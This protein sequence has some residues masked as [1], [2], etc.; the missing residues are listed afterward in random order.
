M[1]HLEAASV[2][3]FERLSRE[4]RAH[5][6]PSSLVR[7]ARESA[8]D[9]VRHA[10]LAGKLAARFGGSPR[11][12][13]VRGNG[14]RSL[15]RVAKENAVEGCVR[16]TY[17]ALVAAWQ[18]THA[19]DARVRRWMRTIARDELRHAA[20]AWAIAAWANE[21]LD[22]GSRTRVA[23]ARAQALEQLRGQV[24][25]EASSAVCDVAGLPSAREARALFGAW[26]SAL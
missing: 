19:R 23:R 6:A 20:L 1:A 17:G 18:A 3:A 2:H 12:A 26:S 13:S 8:R 7:A 15:G 14:V 11:G 10:R 16:E 4:L 21:R 9:E 5:G 24:E 25:Q 22:R